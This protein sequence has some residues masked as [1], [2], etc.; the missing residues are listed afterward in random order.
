MKGSFTQ[1]KHEPMAPGASG[2]AEE[3]TSFGP[4][5]LED[6]QRIRK[7]NQSCSLNPESKT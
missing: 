1:I 5:I 6:E 2:I 4:E 3:I 7:E